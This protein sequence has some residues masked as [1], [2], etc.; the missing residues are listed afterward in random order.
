MKE[1]IFW[2]VKEGGDLWTS[3]GW[4]YT[5]DTVHCRF[6]AGHSLVGILKEKEKVSHSKLF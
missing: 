1:R 6:M 5:S 4:Q 3:N 2:V